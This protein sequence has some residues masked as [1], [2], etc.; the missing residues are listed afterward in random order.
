M[1]QSNTIGADALVD[2]EPSLKTCYTREWLQQRF[3]LF[4]KRLK[5]TRGMQNDPPPVCRMTEDEILEWAKGGGVR[6]FL[7]Q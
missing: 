5:L 6:R 4:A 2:R 3:N 7:E 1:N